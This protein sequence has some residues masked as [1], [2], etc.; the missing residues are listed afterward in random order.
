MTFPADLFYPVGVHSLGI[1]VQ[2]GI[3]HPAKQNVLWVRATNDGLLK[4]K[5]K[6]LPSAKAT[7]DLSSIR[8]LLRAFLANP[9]HPV[10]NIERFQ[11][12]CAIDEGDSLL[13]LVPEK[14]LDEAHASDEEIQSGMEQVLRDTAAFLIGERRGAW[15]SNTARTK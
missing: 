12:A 13:E 2:K 7:N 8:D 6:R 1:F 14:Y 15:G 3:P 5:G 11:K 4:S 10:P 9:G